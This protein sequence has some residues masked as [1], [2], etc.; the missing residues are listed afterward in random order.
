MTIHLKKYECNLYQ[1]ADLVP[2]CLLFL[3]PGVGL[4][5]FSRLH[6]FSFVEMGMGIGVV[7]CW[8][9]EMVKL[10]F[11]LIGSIASFRAFGS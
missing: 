5:C 4:L 6:S 9:C 10:S 11:L 2:F 1:I 8:V 7:P 3:A